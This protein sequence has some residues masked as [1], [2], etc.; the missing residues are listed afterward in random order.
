MTINN[1][2]IVI[3]AQ[4]EEVVK[5]AL[6]CQGNTV[7]HIYNL[8]AAGEQHHCGAEGQQ[9]HITTVQSLVFGCKQQLTSEK[10]NRCLYRRKEVAMGVALP[11][12][13]RAA[14]ND[15]DDNNVTASQ[16]ESCSGSGLTLR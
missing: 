14:V 4:R 11:S 6:L 5:L 8:A 12:C 3:T 2:D 7:V 16:R 9:Q 1:Q 10:I 15:S 13:G